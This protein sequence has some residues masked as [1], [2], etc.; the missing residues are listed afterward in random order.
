M[1]INLITGLPG[2]GKSLRTI[3]EVMRLAEKEGRQVYHEGIPGCSV[4]GWLPLP[5]PLKWYE[6]PQ[7]SII[8]IDECQRWWRSRSSN[9]AVPKHSQELETHRHKGFDLFLMTQQ[10]SLVDPHLR[11]LVGRHVHMQRKFGMEQSMCWEWPDCKDKP[12]YSLRLAQSSLYTFE[13]ELYPLYKSADAH[14]IKRRL[15]R[16]VFFAM[17]LIVLIPALIVG[18]GWYWFKNSFSAVTDSTSKSRAAASLPIHGGGVAPLSSNAPVGAVAA[19]KPVL[20]P[21]APAVAYVLSRE[22]LIP[23][24]PHTAPRYE[25]LVQALSA[26]TPDF[27]V[28]NASRCTCYT[29]QVTRIAMDDALCRSFADGRNFRDWLPRF[30]GGAEAPSAS[31]AAPQRQ[32][33]SEN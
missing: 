33:A 11:A 8:I 2:S 3:G 29:S 17:A 28:S 16:R 24:L 23:S 10:P 30:H 15:P 4:P 26:P 19:P 27:C 25:K 12:L 14:T 22:P 18:S 21:V 6:C 1:P 20:E 13:K 31:A 5:D 7:G 9:S 32:S